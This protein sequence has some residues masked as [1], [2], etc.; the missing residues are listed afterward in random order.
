MANLAAL[1]AAN[2]RRWAVAR[3]QS[4]RKA[5]FVATAN[6]LCKPQNVAYFKDA[7]TR[8]GVPWFV[9]AVIK[10]RE[11]GSDPTFLKNIAQGDPWNK[12]SIH[13]PK[14]RG[15]FASWID[16]AIDA[17]SRC[18]PY[19]SSWKDWTPGGAMTLL[20]QYNGLGYF[21]KGLPSPYVWSGTDQYARGKYIADG[22]FSAG[23]VD[24]QLG[25]AG[26]LLA[27]AEINSEVAERMGIK[28]KAQMPIPP[29]VSPADTKPAKPPIS[30][31]DKA[32]VG[33]A[34]VAA[35]SSIVQW[36]WIAAGIVAAL[37][38]AAFIYFKFVRK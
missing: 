31:T 30:K 4:A 23:T 1:Q 5:E 12:P 18:A 32:I 33:G 22:V 34:V 20:E 36:G 38:I 21:N 35:G 14:G 7:E 25:C 28:N 27:M 37:A 26:I 8:T 10:E 3:I 9:V 2:Q 24:V 19:A 15:P 17:L 6:R 29:D 13:V 11:A 16:A